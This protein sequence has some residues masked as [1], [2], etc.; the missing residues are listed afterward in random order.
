MTPLGAPA[1]SAATACDP[2][3]PRHGRPPRRVR[4]GK[5]V[6]RSTEGS[7]SGVD[8]DEVAEGSSPVD[9]RTE[10]GSARTLSA[11]WAAV[12]PPVPT[13]ATGPKPS[14][15]ATST[16]APSQSTSAAAPVPAPSSTPEGD[17]ARNGAAFGPGAM[18][19][20]GAA[21]LVGGGLLAFAKPRKRAS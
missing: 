14:S 6:D 12:D 2:A 7:G 4:A 21:V 11:G 13:G 18:G 16:L 19:A 8:G 1:A 15:P 9:F 20:A 10:F 17:L 3:S 5:V